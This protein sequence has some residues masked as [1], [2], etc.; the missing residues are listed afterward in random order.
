MRPWRLTFV[1]HQLKNKWIVN[2][3]YLMTNKTHEWLT[4]VPIYMISRI[5][6]HCWLYAQKIVQ[7]KIQ[8]GLHFRTKT[9]R[10]SNPNNAMW[11]T[12]SG[13]DQKTI[14]ILQRLKCILLTRWHGCILIKIKTRHATTVRRCSKNRRCN[15]VTVNQCIWEGK[16]EVLPRSFRQCSCHCLSS[17]ST[18]GMQTK[19]FCNYANALL[20]CFDVCK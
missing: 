2:D 16:G 8:D 9:D 7:T 12:R 1:P 14:S 4:L 6:N 3:L 20:L 5:L 17:P 11:K 15:R 13:D 19:V 18:L 10:V